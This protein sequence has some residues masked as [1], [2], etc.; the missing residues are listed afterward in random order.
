MKLLYVLKES[1]ETLPRVE[2]RENPPEV[3]L[4]PFARS[5]IARPDSDCFRYAAHG[6]RV[7]IRTFVGV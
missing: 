5:I 2:K 3:G 4:R 1:A 7:R 6:S